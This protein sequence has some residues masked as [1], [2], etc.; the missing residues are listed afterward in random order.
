VRLV[1]VYGPPAVGKLT[2]AREL[3]KQ[4]G[5]AVFHNHLV[6]DAVAAVFPFGDPQFVQLR[7]AWWLEMFQAAARDDRS[8]IFTFQPE[9][10]VTE[11]F[12][13]RVVE[14]VSACGGRVDF[15][16][17]QCDAAVLEERIDAESRSAFGKLTSLDLLRE[18]RDSFEAC[19][20]RMPEAVVAIDT[21]AMAPEAAATRI[22]SALGLSGVT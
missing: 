7:E 15:V 10:S 11:D 19:E 6:V 16:R 13:Q 1:F 4:T 17:L 12:P 18:L 22:V 14:A 9:P 20:E 8:M 2:V 3:T 21:G 5:L